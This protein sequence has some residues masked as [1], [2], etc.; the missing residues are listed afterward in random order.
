[1]KTPWR[2][3]IGAPHGWVAQSAEQWTE[4]PSN[5]PPTNCCPWCMCEHW[6]H[7]ANQKDRHTVNMASTASRKPQRKSQKG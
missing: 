4:N 6:R 7:E 2:R 1:M 5:L 3:T